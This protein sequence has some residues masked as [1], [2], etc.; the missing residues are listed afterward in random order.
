MKPYVDIRV[1]EFHLWVRIEKMKPSNFQYLLETFRTSFSR[2]EWDDDQRGWRL[3]IQHLPRVTR[4][5]D[6][7]LGAANVKLR[8]NDNSDRGTRQLTLFPD[9]PERRIDV[10]ITVFR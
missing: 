8:P 9:V 2:A 7:S 5:F 6:E 10:P 4:F 3:P 1:G